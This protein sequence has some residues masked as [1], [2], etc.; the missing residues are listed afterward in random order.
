MLAFTH[1]ETVIAGWAITAG[2]IGAYAWWMA[3]RART[4]SELVP[5]EER[6][7]T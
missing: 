7:W 1:V 4:L 2:V 3:R 5:P 6:R